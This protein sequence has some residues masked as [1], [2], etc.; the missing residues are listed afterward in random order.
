MDEIVVVQIQQ[1]QERFDNIQETIRVLDSEGQDSTELRE[2]LKE[3]QDLLN[4]VT[5]PQVPVRICSSPKPKIHP[6]PYVHPMPKQAL[7]HVPKVVAPPIKQEP[8]KD[9][10]GPFIVPKVVAQPIKR[11]P[12]NDDVGGV[13]DA[14]MQPTVQLAK[15]MKLLAPP[16]ICLP[17]HERP[18]DST[19]L[20][21]NDST[22]LGSVPGPNDST[23]PGPTDSTDRSSKDFHQG[24][25]ILRKVPAPVK[26]GHG[27]NPPPQP[28]QV[29]QWVNTPPRPVLPDNVMLVNGNLMMRPPQAPTR[30]MTPTPPS[31][32]PPF[33]QAEPL[34][35]LTPTPPSMPPPPALLLP[36]QEKTVTS[37]VRSFSN[38]T[39]SFN[40][41]PWNEAKRN[42]L[43]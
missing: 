19:D 39:G 3:A 42:R 8:A 9:G 28:K 27:I 12:A 10:V 22:D 2:S 16:Q 21:P 38:N 14:A 20:G 18:N 32:P 5:E 43:S 37:Q 17:T 15:Q 11:E 6:I 7:A 33:A 23:D 29:V 4:R 31:Y 13:I 25:P 30:V 36:G 26:V 1:L 34:P 40:S 41:A 24:R 35:V